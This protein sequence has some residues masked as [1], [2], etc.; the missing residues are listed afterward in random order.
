LQYRADIDGLRAIAVGSVVLFHAGVP[1]FAGGFVGVDIFFVISGF[2]ITKIIRDSLQE[3]RFSLADFYD[4]RIRRIFPALFAVYLVTYVLGLILLMPGDLKALAKS[5][6]SSAA[7]GANFHFYGNVGYFDAPAITKPLLHTWSL[8]VEEQ[9]YVLWPLAM[10]ALARFVKLRYWLPILLCSLVLSLAYAEWE[11]WRD[12]A[13]A[14]FYMPH[15]RA[16][17]LIT[18]ALL[19][20]ALPRLAFGRRL[21]EA[22]VA[23]GLVLIAA[24][25]ALLSEDR[26]FPG[27]NA[28]FPCLGA[29]LIIAAGARGPTAVSRLLSNKPMVFLGLISY[30]LY[31]WHWPL[32]S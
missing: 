19:A 21:C 3:D 7:F 22:M 6:L 31:L 29:A 4:R 32:F 23:L 20:I 30:S 12:N 10:I 25:I 24:S 18:G 8:S 28:V 14:A 27:L 13:S 26:D 1:G 2:L 16:W 11:V 15:A 5:L 17:E 9:F